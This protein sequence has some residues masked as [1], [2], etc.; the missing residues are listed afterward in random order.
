MGFTFEGVFYKEKNIN[1]VRKTFKNLTK[2][3]SHILLNRDFKDVN[4]YFIG[5][6]N[7]FIGVNYKNH[8]NHSNSLEKIRTISSDY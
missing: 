8:L 2:T 4:N 1:R 3:L 6:N 7:Y 5:V